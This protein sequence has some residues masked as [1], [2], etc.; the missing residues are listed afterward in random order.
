MTAATI[1]DVSAA[2]R[3]LRSA[4]PGRNPQIDE[5]TAALWHLAV[6]SLSGAAVIS[7]A[8]TWVQAQPEFPT[9]VDFIRETRNAQRRIEQ[10]DAAGNVPATSSCRDCD[11]NG[12]IV[13]DPAGQ[14]T[15]RPC[16]RCRP[17]PADRQRGGHYMPNHDCQECR[18]IRQSAPR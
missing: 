1:D 10:A 8:S 9:L 12:W 4:V 5:E 11:G 16:G 7:G 6:S 13:V 2:L 3:I 18:D 17:R 14:T 15:V